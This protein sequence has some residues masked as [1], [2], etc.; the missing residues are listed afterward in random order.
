MK[1]MIHSNVIL[2]HSYINPPDLSLGFKTKITR[3]TGRLKWK[4]PVQRNEI[5]VFN[6]RW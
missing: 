5:Q 3:N 1:I 6:L 4:E 2:G